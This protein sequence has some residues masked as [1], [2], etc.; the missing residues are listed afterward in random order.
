MAHYVSSLSK[1]LPTWRYGLAVGLGCALTL[2]FACLG[3]RRHCGGRTGQRHPRLYH[4]VGQNPLERA[5]RGRQVRTVAALHAQ[6]VYR[7]VWR[8]VVNRSLWSADFQKQDS[9]CERIAGISHSGSGAYPSCC[10]RCL[11][12]ATLLRGPE[13]SSIDQVAHTALASDRCCACQQLG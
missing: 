12:P 10:R 3:A 9:C 5:G 6:L 1:T 4:M 7:D 2:A 8:P 13:A 11:R